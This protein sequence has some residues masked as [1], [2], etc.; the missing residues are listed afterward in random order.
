MCKRPTS[1]KIN[2][3]IN[4]DKNIE[5]ILKKIQPL[6]LKKRPKKDDIKNEHKQKYIGNKYIY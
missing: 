4:K 5:K 3:L 6:L 2:R 1:Q